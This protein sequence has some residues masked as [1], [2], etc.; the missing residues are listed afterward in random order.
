MIRDPKNASGDSR[1]LPVVLLRTSFSDELLR[2]LVDTGSTIDLVSDSVVPLSQPVDTTGARISTLGGPKLRVK[3]SMQPVSLSFEEKEIGSLKMNVVQAPMKDFD[4]I[5]SKIFLERIGTVIDLPGKCLRIGKITVPFLRQIKVNKD[6][7]HSVRMEWEPYNENKT[8]V[9]NESEKENDSFSLF[10]YAGT[11]INKPV[12]LR[13]ANTSLIPE[14]GQG[15]LPVKFPRID[16]KYSVLVEPTVLN[17]GLVIGGCVVSTGTVTALPVINVTRRPIRM[18]RGELVTW[19]LI[20]EDDWLLFNVSELQD[21]IGEVNEVRSE[22]RPRKD[23]GREKGDLVELTRLLNRRTAGA[24]AVDG[25]VKKSSKTR[26]QVGQVCSSTGRELAG[27]EGKF[28]SGDPTLR[29]PVSKSKGELVE[30]LMLEQLDRLADV[31]KDFAFSDKE[32]KEIIEDAVR[33][34]GCSKGNREALKQLL[35]KYRSVLSNSKATIGLCTAYKPRIPLDTTEPIF[36]PQYPIPYKMRQEMTESI[37]EFLQ[38]GIVQP[39][40]SPYNSPSLMVPKRDGGF[41]LVVDFRRLNKHVITD[42]HPLPR[43]SQIMEALYQAKYFSVLDLLHGFYNLEIDSDDR[44]KTAFST[45]DGHWEFIR[46]PMGLK[47]SPSIFQRLMQIVL[48]GCL[49]SY[50]FIYIDDILVFS[51]TEAK[52]LEHLENILSKLQIAGLKIKASKIQLF[53]PEVEYLGFLTGCDGLKVNPRKMDSIV[54]FPRPAK[55]RDVQAFLGLIGYFRIFIPKFAEKARPLYILL[56]QDNE[57]SW[58][59]EQEAAF[60]QFKRLLQQAPIL[61]FP[62]FDEPF[63]LTTDASGYAAGAILTQMQ[64]NKERLIACASK[65]FTDTEQRYSNTEREMTAVIYGIDHFKSYLWGNKFI[66][67][68]DNTAVTDLARQEKTTNKKAF[69]WYTLLH[70]YDFEIRHRDGQRMKHADALSRYPSSTEE[71]IEFQNFYLSPSWQNNE[72]EPIFD[73]EIWKKETAEVEVPRNTEDFRYEKIDGL[74]YRISKGNVRVMYVPINLRKRVM[75]LYHDTPSVGHNGYK[76]MLNA[77]RQSLYWQSMATEIGAYVASCL[78]C[79]RNKLLPARTPLSARP[80][81]A[82]CLE[83]VSL[84]LVGKLPPSRYGYQYVL[85]VQDQLSRY[86]AFIP[87]RDKEGPTVAK[88]FL[89]EWVCRYGIPKVIVSDRGTEFTAGIFQELCRFMGTKHSP[90]AAYRPQGNA[91]NERA[92]QDLHTYLTMYLEGSSVSN[93]AMLLSFAA[94]SHNSAIHS[95]LGK[96]P[97]EIL[98]GIKPRDFSAFLP[99]MLDIRNLDTLEEYLDKREDQI[100]ILREQTRLAIQK[101][102]A[103]TMERANK[104]ARFPKYQEGQ[105]VWVKSRPLTSGGRKWGSKYKGPYLIKKVVSDQILELTL[106]D[107]STF[108][109]F[110]HA[111]Y[112]RPLVERQEKEAQVDSEIEPLSLHKPIL[113]PLLSTDC[114]KTVKQCHEGIVNNDL[115]S[116]EINENDEDEIRDEAYDFPFNFSPRQLNQDYSP[117]GQIPISF[118]RTN[119]DSALGKRI[120]RFWPSPIF[121][122]PSTSARNVT[123]SGSANKVSENQS[124]FTRSSRST[125]SFFSPPSHDSSSSD[126]NSSPDTVVASGTKTMRERVQAALPSLQS[127]ARF[128]QFGS[129]NAENSLAVPHNSQHAPN[130]RVVSAQRTSPRVMGTESQVSPSRSVTGSGTFPGSTGEIGSSRYPLRNRIAISDSR[131]AIVNPPNNVDL[132]RGDNAQS[133]VQDQGRLTNADTLPQQGSSQQAAETAKQKLKDSVP[134]WSGRYKQDKY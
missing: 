101:A 64:N 134:L 4:G 18:K 22:S 107:D 58:G 16:R 49:G 5:L 67:F 15:Y 30:E 129:S 119:P 99:G 103:S 114:E 52:H 86:I 98:T 96:S 48:S 120:A 97:L 88:A 111:T 91:E 43:I 14:W 37:K 72:F 50:A 84:D 132:R 36:T 105:L 19:G 123:N 80:A 31:A 127:A 70:E 2:F 35:W 55:V 20:V 54:N 17:N 9:E 118:A 41:R 59:K 104:F 24:V 39:S 78:D 95:V 34:S 1:E 77:I 116:D 90:T 23:R 62:N 113:P 38:L 100:K 69:K 44:R 66:V 83:Q 40:S 56:K 8:I 47:N 27:E 126:G 6:V 106:P 121:T 29:R 133:S 89:N 68:T 117:Q 10:H 128:L 33:K 76:R 108:S 112:I 65:V 79:Q 46:L 74:I 109:D 73:L 110:V 82:E 131:H 12:S 85:C 57:W 75:F 94:W 13:C 130:N 61:A 53:L 71:S 28:S 124:R 63:M 87:I 102:Q 11:K 26:E 115:G 92:H 122:K 7:L 21:D 3:G 42:F 32:L 51:T 25:R 81:P 45:Y 93:W 125:G 60:Q